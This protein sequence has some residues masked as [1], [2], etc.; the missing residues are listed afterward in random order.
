MHSE[1]MSC[2][3]YGDIT[4]NSYTV[5]ATET[6]TYWGVKT[7]T[8]PAGTFECEVTQTD[9]GDSIT[10]D[11]YCDDVGSYVKSAYEHG[12]SGSGTQLLISY[13][14]TPPDTTPPTVS[15]TGPLAGAHIRGSYVDVAWQSAD[16]T[17]IVSTEMRIDGG[18]WEL[19]SG[20]EVNHMQ[21]SSG[22][23]VIEIRVTDGAGNQ[24][25]NSTSFE[26]DNGAFSFGGPYYGLPVVAI[27]AGVILVGLFVALTVLKRRRAPAAPPQPP[28]TPPNAP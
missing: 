13:S 16:N 9:D 11:W 12:S 18:T 22:H 10:T 25:V 3:F 14:Y 23:H 17:G 1:T 6:L 27:I 5:S 20:H 26:S 2:D 7:I 4:E 19:V 24:A 15:M 28:A 21:L 8:V